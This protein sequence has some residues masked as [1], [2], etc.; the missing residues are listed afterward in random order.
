MEIQSV[1]FKRE[2]ISKWEKGLVIRSWNSEAEETNSVIVDMKSN[3]IV[4]NVWDI[5]YSYGLLINFN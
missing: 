1:K 5:E 3:P 2:E 4:N